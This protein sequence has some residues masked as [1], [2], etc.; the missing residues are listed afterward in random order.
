MVKGD[1]TAKAIANRIK[2]KGLQRLRWYC[3][4]CEKQCRDENGFKNHCSSESHQRQMMLF[5]DNSGRY[6]TDYSQR[7][8]AEFMALLSSRYST[9]RVQANVVYNE[10][11]SDRHHTHMNATSWSS[12]SAYVMYLG[13]EGLCEVEDTEKG[14]YIR[15][16]DRRPET[17]ARQEAVLKKE[18]FKRS[19]DERE[20][21]MLAEQIEKATAL[22][23]SKQQQ[24]SAGTEAADAAIAE[25]ADDGQQ[26][27]PAAA[28]AA[29]GQAAHEGVGE[30]EGD[31]PAATPAT[32]FKRENPD[33]P[34]KL[35]F[36]KPSAA[37]SGQTSLSLNLKAPIKK[38][39]PKR[40]NVLAAAS[41]KSVTSASA[42]APASGSASGFGFGSSAGK[43]NVQQ[44]MPQ[45][46][47][48]LERV[49]QDEALKKKRAVERSGGSSG[50]GS[51]S[52]G[53]DADKRPRHL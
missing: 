33:Q 46:V 12:L 39:E 4:M 30:G 22:A 42:S 50:G 14:W 31:L 16:I 44:Q 10:F 36:T 11:V 35:S 20:R 3:Q 2:A 53:R 9:R 23:M 51:G 43:P 41:K 49:L 26:T 17:L 6:L 8:H 19:D 48:A 1:N 32:D 52:S 5:A 18:R 13:K 28:A 25:T 27:D 38:L 7:F 40:M 45:P 21:A 47:S 37:G 29:T 34:I 15:W 24:Q